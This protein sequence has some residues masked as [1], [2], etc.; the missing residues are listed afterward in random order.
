MIVF[1]GSEM[2]LIQSILND[3][4][5][6]FMRVFARFSYI[7]DFVAFVKKLT[8]RSNA[9][10]Y[11]TCL[12]SNLNNS[13]FQNIDIDKFIS[14]LKVNGVNKG[15]E[16]PISLVEEI[17]KYSE[18][19]IVY[20]Y[21]DPKLGFM[22]SD[23]K[24]ACSFLNRE[25][26]L[27]QY[28]NIETTCPAIKKI[29]SDPMI[30]LIAM[31]Y[32]GCVPKFLGANL[33]WTFPIKPNKKDQLKHAHFYHRDIDDYKFLKF[34][35]YITDVD[36]GDGGHWVVSGSHKEAPHIELKDKFLIRRFEDKEVFNFY[37]SDNIIEI[38]GSKGLGFVEDTLCVH[39][40]ATPTG[41]PRLVLQLQFGLYGFVPE[42]DKKSDS[43]LQRLI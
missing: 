25:I 42:H 30:N 40:A 6:T 14:S 33:W 10:T 12:I 27:A 39:K 1:Y 3:P 18:E 34:F 19:N 16:L 5:Y 9:K 24:R 38:T 32:L 20:A 22:L 28:F 36:E 13:L 4:K 21:R 37:H 35:F 7:R 29:I 26:L 17:E 8:G 2:A 11:N 23:F 31:R 41:K 15:L 43:D